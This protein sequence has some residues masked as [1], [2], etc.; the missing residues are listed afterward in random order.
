MIII[1]RDV[2]GK[3]GLILKENETKI[4]QH[5]THLEVGNNY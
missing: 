1:C 5:R 2:D 4:S 3:E